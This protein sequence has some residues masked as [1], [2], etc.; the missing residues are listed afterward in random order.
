MKLPN[1]LILHLGSVFNS[2]S[3]TQ[4]ILLGNHSANLEF[5]LSQPQKDVLAFLGQQD[6]CVH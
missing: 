1:H 3:S 4:L 6:H 2:Q 5:P